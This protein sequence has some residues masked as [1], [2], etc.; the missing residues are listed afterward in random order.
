MNIPSRLLPCFILFGIILSACASTEK[1]EQPDQNKPGFSQI[2]AKEAK[3]IMDSESDC[4]ILDVRTAEEFA[5]GHVPG[6][7]LIP[8]DVI[9]ERAE[10]EL[11]KKDQMILVYCRSDKRSL[12]ASETL[13]NAGYTHVISFGGILDWPYEIEQ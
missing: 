7:I 5:E 8:Y 12:I 6:A 9:G 2:D 3:S 10:K 1:Q 13:V 4:I 11:P